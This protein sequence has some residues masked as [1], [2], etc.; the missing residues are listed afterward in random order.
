MINNEILKKIVGG[1]IIDIEL[2]CEKVVI[3]TDKGIISL[4]HYQDCCE[5]VYLEDICGAP[6]DCI[7]EKII[8]FEERNSD[9]TGKPEVDIS[10]YDSYTWTFYEMRTTGGDMNLRW[11]GT[12]N[13]H[14]SE[15]VSVYYM[16]N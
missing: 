3:V 4:A 5:N 2:S 10:N 12:S 8:L 16:E 9:T 1:K 11:L 14:Y 13:G 15:S 7:G 6:E